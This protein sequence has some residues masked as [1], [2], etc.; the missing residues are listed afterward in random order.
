MDTGDSEL[1]RGN[2]AG[3]LTRKPPQTAG[4]VAEHLDAV[5]RRLYARVAEYIRK[6]VAE[7]EYPRGERLPSET[8][9]A[10]KLG[11]SRATLREA[12]RLLEDEG[13][14][15]SRRGAGSFVRPESR[16]IVEGLEKLGSMT[17]S[18]RR[19]GFTAED[20]VLSVSPIVLSNHTAKSLRVSNGSPGYMVETLRLANGQPVIYSCDIIKASIFP[21]P[22]TVEKRRQYES[23]LDFLWETMGIQIA[24]CVEKVRI[25]L[26]APPIT[27]LLSVENGTPLLM[28]EGVAHDVSDEPVYID[29]SYFRSDIYDFVLVRRA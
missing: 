16:R 24:Y 1:T 11:V 9:L 7:G 13:L 20:R 26:A 19:A 29:S 15:M 3:R 14:V 2:D 8:D 10:S 23:L 12:L 6:K 17:K 25:L 5:G 28:M 21:E 18:I 27:H 4:D 22:G